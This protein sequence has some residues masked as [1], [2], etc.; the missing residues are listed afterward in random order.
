MSVQNLQVQKYLSTKYAPHIDV[1]DIGKHNESERF[2]HLLT[3][4]L[5][6]LSLTYFADL[7]VEVACASVT[8]EPHDNGIDAIYFSSLDKSL[9]IVQSKWSKNEATIDV[10]STHKFVALWETLRTR[11]YFRGAAKLDLRWRS[12]NPGYGLSRLLPGRMTRC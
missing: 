10:G 6:A 1:S 5:A 2:K 8:D 4:G 7:E 3:E 9:Y 12:L 11:S